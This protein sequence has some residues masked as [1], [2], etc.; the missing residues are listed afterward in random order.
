MSP[1]TVRLSR[2]NQGASVLDSHDWSKG[3]EAR[4]GGIVPGSARLESGSLLARIKFPVARRWRGGS[5]RT[6]R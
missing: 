5:R 3:L 6:C 4:L 2:L 1:K